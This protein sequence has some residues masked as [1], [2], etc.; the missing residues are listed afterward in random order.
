MKLLV[1]EDD[2]DLNGTIVKYLKLKEFSVDSALDGEEALNLVYENSYDLIVL[3]VKLP[4]IDGF[5]VAKA[6]RE[7]SD[8][9]I[10][11]L[12]SLD[13]QKD[14]QKGF[15]SGGDDYITKPFSLNEL[16]LRVKAVLKRVYKNQEVIKIADNIEFFIDKELLYKDGE[17]I[18]LTPKETRLLKL[19]LQNPNKILSKDEITNKIYDYNEELSEGT[20]RVF[21]TNLRKIIGKNKIQTVKNLGYFYVE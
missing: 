14:I 1:V 2:K 12:T 17:I 6:I 7:F 5:E 18:H 4:K 21:I 8:V 16:L 10:I 3:D 15:L 19:F 20:L 13:S 9:P 11:F